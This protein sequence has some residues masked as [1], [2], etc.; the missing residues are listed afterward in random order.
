[1]GL[2]TKGKDMDIKRLKE[3]KDSGGTVHCIVTSRFSKN[4]VTTGEYEITKVGRKY[5]S[6]GSARDKANI[7][8]LPN[9]TW[10]NGYG[11]VEMFETSYA[12]CAY[13]HEQYLRR[14][15]EKRLREMVG[16]GCRIHGDLIKPLAELL[17][18]TT[19]E[20]E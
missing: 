11:T 6:L 20:N 17:G 2:P 7:Y 3:I 15:V 4:K 14:E 8:Q 18:V 12:M 9:G 1:M 19:N 5:I 13:S 16:V 10:G